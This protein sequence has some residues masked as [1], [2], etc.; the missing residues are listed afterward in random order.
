MKTQME[1]TKS[2]MNS[3]NKSSIRNS[4]LMFTCRQAVLWI[5]TLLNL[6]QKDTSKNFNQNRCKTHSFRSKKRFL[7]QVN[8]LT[9]SWI[10][11]GLAARFTDRSLLAP[12]TRTSQHTASRSSS[13][14][15]LTSSST[16]I[17]SP[18]N[19]RQGYWNNC[20]NLMLVTA[21]N[22]CMR[23][24]AV[25]RLSIRSNHLSLSLLCRHNIRVSLRIRSL[26]CCQLKMRPT[27]MTSMT[28]SMS[29]ASS[30][31]NSSRSKVKCQ[32]SLLKK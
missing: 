12:L 4:L 26:A 9:C 22:D 2:E 19:R 17:Q 3:S 20:V 6:S 30:W 29:R 32:P 1:P 5:E 18:I 10:V 27:I 8:P 25:C 21:G 14:C 31:A 24:R 13:Y 7:T 23:I 11:L 16:K 15:K 28:T